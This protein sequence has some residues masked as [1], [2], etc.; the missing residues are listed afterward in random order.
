MQRKEG[1][2]RLFKILEEK[3]NFIRNDI[4]QEQR[5][6]EE[7]VDSI[8]SNLDNDIPKILDFIKQ[9]QQQREENDNVIVSRN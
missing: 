8:N 2:N 7:L 4:S 3:S 6:R 9:E 1:E 5:M